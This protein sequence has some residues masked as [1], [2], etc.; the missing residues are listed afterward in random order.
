[1]F[2]NYENLEYLWS[3]NISQFYLGIHLRLLNNANE[4]F[5]AM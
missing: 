3:M 2:Q 4:S 1:M 5:S